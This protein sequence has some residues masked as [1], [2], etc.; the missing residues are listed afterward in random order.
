MSERRE[1]LLVFL[2]GSAKDKKTVEK[3]QSNLYKYFERVWMVR[4]NHMKN[5]LPGNSL[6]MLNLCY[7]RGC[8]HPLCGDE[9]A[10]KDLKWYD[11]EPL[12][13]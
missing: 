11:D 4:E 6:F 5:D 13:T 12:L 1:S 2:K 7:Q 3:E 8:R 9:T 10:R